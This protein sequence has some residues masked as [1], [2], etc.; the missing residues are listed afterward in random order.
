MYNDGF[1]KEKKRGSLNDD[2][3]AKS[4]K[5]LKRKNSSINQGKDKLSNEQSEGGSRA[6]PKLNRDKS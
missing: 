6:V 1:K 2:V 3:P 5:K 4:F